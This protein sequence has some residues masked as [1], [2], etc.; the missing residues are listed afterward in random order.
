MAEMKH[1]EQMTET[2]KT[3]AYKGF[4]R[5]DD[6]E[7]VHAKFVKAGVDVK[8]DTFYRLVGGELVEEMR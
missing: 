7:I 5:N 4:E 1:E 3:I 2:T 8:P 6:G